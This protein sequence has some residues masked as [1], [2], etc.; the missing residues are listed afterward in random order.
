[1]PTEPS[2]SEIMLAVCAVEGKLDV[3]LKNLPA[4]AK[5][6]GDRELQRQEQEK[7]RK[8]KAAAGRVA[9]GSGR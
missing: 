3:L 4:L 1:M 9:R 5:L 6:T 7:A 8:L 2:N